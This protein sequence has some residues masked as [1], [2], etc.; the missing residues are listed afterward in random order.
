M[1]DGDTVTIQASRDGGTLTCRFIV[2][3]TVWSL[4]HGLEIPVDVGTVRFGT[5][6]RTVTVDYIRVF[7]R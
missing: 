6:G 4:T 5:A 7:S 1:S 2:G 3:G